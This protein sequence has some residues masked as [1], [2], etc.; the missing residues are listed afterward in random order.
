M[1]SG[2]YGAAQFGRNFAGI[3]DHMMLWL[4]VR[5]HLTQMATKGAEQPSESGASPELPSLPT[6]MGDLRMS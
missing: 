6:A 5:L 3:K 4:E 2:I 1:C